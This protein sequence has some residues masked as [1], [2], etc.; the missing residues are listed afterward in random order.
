[1]ATERI[2]PTGLTIPLPEMSGADPACC[3]HCRIAGKTPP[4]ILS[5]MTKHDE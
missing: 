2:V 1:M 3:Q 4:E 5:C